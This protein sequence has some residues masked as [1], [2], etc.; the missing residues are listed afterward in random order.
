MKI[1]DFFFLNEKIK[2]FGTSA[3]FRAEIRR[4]QLG[5]ILLALNCFDVIKERWG[6]Q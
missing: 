2:G 4:S 6:E 1:S 3:L 5:R